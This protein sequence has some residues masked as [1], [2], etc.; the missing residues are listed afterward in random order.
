LKGGEKTIPMYNVDQFDPKIPNEQ[1]ELTHPKQ[2]GTS[3]N[4]PQPYVELKVSPPPKPR[5]IAPTPL[6]YLPTTR[7]YPS[8]PQYPQVPTQITPLGT[9]Q[10]PLNVVN[11]LVIGDQNPYQDHRHIHMIY[12]DVLPMKYLPN[13]LNTLSERLTLGSFIKSSIL[14]GKDGENIPYKSGENNLSDK[15]KTTDLNPYHNTDDVMKNNPYLTLPK[16]ML[17]FRSCYPIKRDSTSSNIVVCAKDSVGMNLRLYRLTQGEMMINKTTN[18]KFYDS[19]VWREVMCYEY[20][21]ENIIRKKETPNFVMMIG[22][23]VCND[24][25]IDFDNI[26]QLKQPTFKVK[27][28]PEPKLKANPQ[29]GVMELNPNA[30]ACDVLTAI[31]ESPTY[32]LIQW[33]SRTYANVGQSKKMMNM[34]FH[35]DDI[36]FS[37]IFQIM[38]GMLALQKHHISYNEF[39][40]RD[41]IYIKD[42]SNTNNITSYWKYVV[43]DIS[44]YIPNYGFLVMIDSKFKDIKSSGM[45]V[46]NNQ[47]KQHK[48]ISEIFSD[49]ATPQPH[50]ITYDINES[51]LNVLNMNNFDSMFTQ[52]GGMSPSDKTQRVIE[53]I[54][55]YASAQNAIKTVVKEYI[56]GDC[57]LRYM[58]RFLN[59]RIGTILSKQEQED[60]NKNGKVFSKGDIIIYEESVNVFKFVVFY[61]NVN[62]H[63]GYVEIINRNTN[64]LDDTVIQR[65]PIGNLYEYSKIQQVKQNYKPNETKLDESDLLETYNIH[66]E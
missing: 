34:G 10:A 52:N 6:Q 1:K 48:I 8:Y 28:Q 39:N 27:L 55:Q 38:V 51:F 2:Q 57:I 64:N 21:R 25:L 20:I 60:I 24:C 47:Q 50:A 5:Q 56:I 17:L 46:G 12:E 4:Q 59:N 62:G 30:Y 45:T 29:T 44:Y 16:N 43:N 32:S 15:L 9:Y 26:E 53:N 13:S 11:Q 22:Y 14:L 54:N 66:D 49:P 18:N 40:L 7:L 65:V 63:V 41:N 31:T 37:I 3:F 35:T 61:R 42:L 23:S 58:G 19:E 33:A 36:W